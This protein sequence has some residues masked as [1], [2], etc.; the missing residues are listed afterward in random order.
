MAGCSERQPTFN[1]DF[2]SYRIKMMRIY[3]VPNSTEM[4]DGKPLGNRPN[5]NLIG[6]SVSAEGFP[7]NLNSPIPISISVCHPQPAGVGFMHAGNKAA[8]NIGGMDSVF[9][10]ANHG[11]TS[12]AV[13]SSSLFYQGIRMADTFP[14]PGRQFPRLPNVMMP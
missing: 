13:V 10:H 9:K 5:E 7:S 3:A 1:V 4:V 14:P 12:S 2:Q 6:E 8:Y 11:R